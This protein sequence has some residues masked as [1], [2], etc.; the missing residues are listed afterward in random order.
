MITANDALAIPE[1]LVLFRKRYGMSQKD[2][3]SKLNC[4]YQRISRWENGIGC[5]EEL[6]LALKW[7]ESELLSGATSEKE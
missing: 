1:L 2:L 7:L 3:A 6:R 5:R 4:N